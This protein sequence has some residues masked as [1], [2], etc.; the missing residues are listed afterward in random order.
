MLGWQAGCLIL[1]LMK[2]FVQRWFQPIGQ[3]LVYLVRG[4]RVLLH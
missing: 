2:R 3:Y 1:C 4:E